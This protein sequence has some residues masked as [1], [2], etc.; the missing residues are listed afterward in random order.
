MSLKSF[1]TIA[2]NRRARYDYEVLDQWQV[3]IALLGSEVKSLRL[4]NVRLPESY[5]GEHQGDLYLLNL[6][7]GPYANAPKQFQHDPTRPRRL[8]L[9]KRE[10]NRL[11]GRVREQ[12]L[13]LVPLKLY[14]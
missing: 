11:L 3:G 9:H 7:I 12:R 14:F 2:E 6:H 8:L 4:G 5:A 13:T 1:G 10:R